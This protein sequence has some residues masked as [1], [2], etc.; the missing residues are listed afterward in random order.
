MKGI[1]PLIGYI[2][3][4]A[5]VVILA[6]TLSPWLLRI[7]DQSTNQTGE[8]VNKEIYC[9]D[10]SYDFVSDYGTQGVEWDFSGSGDYLRVKIKNYGT[11]NIWSFSF[12]FELADYSLVRFDAT[13]DSQIE[14]ADPLKPGETA[15]I[16]ANIT[17]DLTSAL[18]R[19]SVRNGMDCT[20]LSQKA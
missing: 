17:Q 5:M 4:L 20:P 6:A 2:M 19:I 12:E 7:T 11:V 16:E 3:L 13:Q 18:S 1:S 9:R 10:I 14:R 15:I 8:D